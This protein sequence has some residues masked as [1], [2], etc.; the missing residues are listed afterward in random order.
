MRRLG[1]IKEIPLTQAV[2]AISC[3][4]Y[5]GEA[6][7]DLDYAED[8]NAGADA[9][10]VLGGNG[11]IVEVQATAEDVPFDRAAYDKMFDL[12]EKGCKELFAK[13]RAAIGV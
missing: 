4:I 11:G 3:G 12:A 8:S 10:F 13:Q 7:L 1:L 9:N 2:A 6:V 5:Q